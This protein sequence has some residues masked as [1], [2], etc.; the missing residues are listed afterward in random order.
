VVKT[1]TLPLPPPDISKET[2]E[3]R[4]DFICTKVAD[5]ASVAIHTIV[6]LAD[7]PNIKLRSFKITFKKPEPPLMFY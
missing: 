3:R 2:Q 1:G 6:Y 5:L 4:K 7:V